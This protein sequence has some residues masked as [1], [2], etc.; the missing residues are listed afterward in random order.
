MLEDF[1]QGYAFN[2]YLSPQDYHHVH[3]P[4]DLMIK[5]LIYLP[6]KLWPVNDWA[7]NN[8]ADLF[9]VNERIAIFFDSEFGAGVLIMVGACNVGKMSLAFHEL[10]T[11]SL[12]PKTHSQ[13]FNFETPVALS[14]GQLLGTFNLGSSVVLVFN[15][16]QVHA[17]IINL[18]FPRKIKM[19]SAL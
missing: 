9:A 14:A 13:T 3:A 1:K 19:V 2:F 18:E 17:V 5:K 12:P 15:K 16:P 8:I 7:V 11:N 6:G 10:I 4:C